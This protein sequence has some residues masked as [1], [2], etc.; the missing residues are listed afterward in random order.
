MEE[1]GGEKY[2]HKHGDCEGLL[3]LLTF[4][5]LRHFLFA[6]QQNGGCSTAVLRNWVFVEQK[7]STCLV[8]EFGTVV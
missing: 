1:I 2:Q 8:W 5:I 6:E 7:G 4:L 3:I